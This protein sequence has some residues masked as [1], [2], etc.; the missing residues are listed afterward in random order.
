MLP[1][2]IWEEIASIAVELFGPSWTELDSQEVAAELLE[3]CSD[4]E[5]R[6]RDLTDISLFQ[7]SVLTAQMFAY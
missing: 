7:T 6:M 1:N 5:Y 2:P 4:W 3:R